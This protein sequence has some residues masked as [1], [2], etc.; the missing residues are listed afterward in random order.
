MT[1]D[2]TDPYWDYD[3][4]EVCWNC[5]GEGFVAHCFEE[6]ACMYPD[7]GCELCMRRCEFCDAQAIE[8]R[9]AETGTGSVAD[10]SAVPERNAP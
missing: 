5:G 8:A 6:W 9:R 4:S 1:T 10:E 3:D 2:E 7:E